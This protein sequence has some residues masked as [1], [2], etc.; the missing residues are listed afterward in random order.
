MFL[1]VPVTASFCLL[2]CHVTSGP[3]GIS[4]GAGLECTTGELIYIRWVY[5]MPVLP[6]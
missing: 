4:V 6:W 1:S 5:E 2:I 3:S